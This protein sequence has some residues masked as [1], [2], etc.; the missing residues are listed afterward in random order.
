MLLGAGDEIRL[1]HQNLIDQWYNQPH[2][3]TDK[4]Y[5]A[6]DILM[7][8]LMSGVYDDVPPRRLEDYFEMRLHKG[9]EDGN[10][11]L[12]DNRMTFPIHKN[13]RYGHEPIELQFPEELLPMLEWLRMI[14]PKRE[15]LLMNRKHEKMNASMLHG[16]LRKHYGFGVDLLRSIFLTD[17]YGNLPTIADRERLAAQMGHSVNTQSNC[18]IKKTF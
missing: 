7:T 10:R 2:S 15:Y 11:F 13:K 9:L 3:F 17:K 12:D 5:L 14:R 1:V 18:Y 4:I 8:G 16:R 6:T